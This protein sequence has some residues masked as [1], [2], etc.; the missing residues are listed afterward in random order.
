MSLEVSIVVASPSSTVTLSG[1][2][3]SVTILPAATTAVVSPHV[4]QATILPDG[5]RIVRLN[6]GPAGP[7]G[8]AGEPGDPGEAGPAGENA[9]IVLLTLAEYL[10]LDPEVQTDGRWYVIPKTT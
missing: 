7:A 3:G 1:Q 8:E 4:S 10:A 2:G 6:T 5:S 9:E